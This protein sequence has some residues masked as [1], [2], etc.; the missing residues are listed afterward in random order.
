[1][2]KLLYKERNLSL[3]HFQS[4]NVKHEVPVLLVPPLMVSNDIFDLTPSHSFVNELLKNGFNVYLIDFQKP[5]ARDSNV[6]LDS[7]ILD[8]LYR[9]V[10]M[11]KKHTA[12]NQISLVGYCL[13]ATFSLAY[14]CSSINIKEDIK[15]VV[16]ISGPVDFRHLNFFNK[17]IEPRRNFWI[18]LVNAYGY[19][20]KTLIMLMFKFSNPM[21][22][23][24]R[25][26]K[27]L[28]NIRNKKYLEK[29]KAVNRFFNNFYNIPAEAFHQ[30]TNAIEKNALINGSMKLMDVSFN[31]SDFNANLLTIA[32]AKDTFTPAES[33][34]A[35]HQYINTSD[36][37]HVEFPFGH[38]SIMNSSKAKETTWS[39]AIDWLKERSSSSVSAPEARENC[40]I[41]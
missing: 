8:K 20:P 34:S 26:F 9:A 37:N 15:N 21:G 30:A 10:F 35:V 31:L 14:S 41:N 36:A 5:D 33:V 23:I 18:R 12:V 39:T 11:T 22:F 4:D 29:S 32:G 3:Y 16:S 38:L 27:L 2:K 1:M 13:G 6:G 40:A 7:Y 19:L 17:I 28:K 25:P 24:K